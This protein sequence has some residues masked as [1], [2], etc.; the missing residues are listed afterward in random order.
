MRLFVYGT[1]K[2]E[3]QFAWACGHRNARGLMALG[4]RVLEGYRWEPQGRIAAYPTIVED[5]N[6]SVE[7]VLYQ[8][9]SLDMAHLDMY[10]GAPRLYQRT[11]VELEDGP[12]IAYVQNYYYGNTL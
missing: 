9:T 3:Q 1:L 6:A 7:G 11:I 10:E 5:R 4:P 8:V 12:A 2:D